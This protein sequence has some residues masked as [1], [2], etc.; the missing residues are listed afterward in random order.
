M[1]MTRAEILRQ[2]KIWDVKVSVFQP[3]RFGQWFLNTHYPDLAEPLIFYG[4]NE[5]KV[6][7]MILNDPRFCSETY[8]TNQ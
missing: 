7:N 6:L 1:T 8:Q 4:T 2:F 3:L 5:R